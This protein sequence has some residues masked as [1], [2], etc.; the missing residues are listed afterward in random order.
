[1]TNTRAAKTLRWFLFEIFSDLIRNIAVSLCPGAPSPTVETGRFYFSSVGI[2]FPARPGGGSQQAELTN[3]GLWVKLGNWSLNKLIFV[4]FDNPTGKNCK[5]VE[6]TSGLGQRSQV[7]NLL[8]PLRFIDATFVY[9]VQSDQ[10]S[11]YKQ[12]HTGPAIQQ[13]S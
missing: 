12:P 2:I 7:N 4:S 1:M 8:F 10:V 11:H 13:T 3:S 6:V 5:S 9:L